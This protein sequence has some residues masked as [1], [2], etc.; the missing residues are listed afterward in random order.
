M[1][2]LKKTHEM[3]IVEQQVINSLIVDRKP[4]RGCFSGQR[5][6]CY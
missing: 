4:A 6:F 5:F 2:K 1:N 3:E